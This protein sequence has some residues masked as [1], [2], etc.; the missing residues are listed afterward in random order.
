LF[1]VEVIQGVL[2]H[3]LHDGA[4]VSCLGRYW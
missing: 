3:H 1:Q 2:L 4:W